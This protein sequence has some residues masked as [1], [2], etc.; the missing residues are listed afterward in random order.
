TAAPSAGS[1]TGILRAGASA[2]K[3]NRIARH[4]PRMRREA[5]RAPGRAAGAHPSEDEIDLLDELLAGGITHQL[6]PDLASLEEE[7]GRDR[8]DSIRDGDRLRSVDVE[9]GHLKPR[10]KLCCESLDGRP[11]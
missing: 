9:V 4:V 3:P 6:I 2:A 8:Q 7:N 10:S 11:E 1:S 5:R